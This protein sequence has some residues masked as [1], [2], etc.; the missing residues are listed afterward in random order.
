MILWLQ[1]LISCRQCKIKRKTETETGIKKGNV[2]RKTDVAGAIPKVQLDL[3]PRIEEEKEKGRGTQKW[4][5]VGLSIKRKAEEDVD[6][7]VRRNMKT[8]KKV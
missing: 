7:K 3:N 4:R 2:V 1:S 8:P 6:M 5:Q